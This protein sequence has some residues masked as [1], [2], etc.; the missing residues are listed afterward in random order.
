MWV[1]SSG[2]V[3]IEGPGPI[4]PEAK[5]GTIRYHHFDSD[6]QVWVLAP[7]KA[8]QSGKLKW[9]AATNG[10]VH[11]N[12]ESYCLQVEGARAPTWVTKSTL[13]T[14]GGRRRRREGSEKVGGGDVGGGSSAV[15]RRTSARTST[16]VSFS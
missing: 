13:T 11:P 6:I 1:K 2:S 15:P 8:A 14:Y 7:V 3:P 10:L 5:P 4:P 12:L 16:C 9:V